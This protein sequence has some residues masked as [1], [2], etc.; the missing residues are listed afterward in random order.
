[1]ARRDPNAAVYRWKTARRPCVIHTCSTTVAAIR[2]IVGHA[3]TNDDQPWTAF[4]RET[5]SK[6]HEW[7]EHVAGLN[8]RMSL[9]KAIEDYVHT[10]KSRA[11][12]TPQDEQ[13]AEL[14]LAAMHLHGFDTV[15]AFLVALDRGDVSL[16]NGLADGIGADPPTPRAKNASSAPIEA[17]GSEAPTAAHQRAPRP[18]GAARQARLRPSSEGA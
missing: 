16:G 11:E 7:A 5:L 9:R 1:M 12:V 17:A 15:D 2:S 13:A 4:V 18:R 10:L 14:I 8:P 6:D 3:M